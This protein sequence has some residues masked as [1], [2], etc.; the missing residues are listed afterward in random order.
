M[1]V[2]IH[3]KTYDERVSSGRY[4][5]VKYLG[6]ILWRDHYRV[7]DRVDGKELTLII[8]LDANEYIQRLQREETE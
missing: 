7:V 5:K 4:A 8:L 6:S 3:R 2:S 1:S